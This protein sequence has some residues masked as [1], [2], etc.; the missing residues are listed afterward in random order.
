MLILKV[1]SLARVCVRLLYRE[2]KSRTFE[3]DLLMPV[4]LNVNPPRTK[5]CKYIWSLRNK[6]NW[7]EWSWE[8]DILLITWNIHG[9]EETWRNETTTKNSPSSNI[10]WHYSGGRPTIKR[11]IIEV[12]SVANWNLHVGN[13]SRP[14]SWIPHYHL[15]NVLVV[16]A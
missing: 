9:N 2:K 16:F 15:H 10:S 13:K 5:I 3:F 12:V 7:S 6:V 8:L 4:D 11:L 1:F 14:E